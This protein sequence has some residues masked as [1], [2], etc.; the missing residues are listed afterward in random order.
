[1]KFGM[2]NYTSKN[3]KPQDLSRTAKTTLGNGVRETILSPNYVAFPDEAMTRFAQER[4]LLQHKDIVRIPKPVVVCQGVVRQATTLPGSTI[5]AMS[6]NVPTEEW[7][8]KELVELAKLQRKERELSAEPTTLVGAI[9]ELNKKNDGR[10]T[11]AQQRLKIKGAA[12]LDESDS[13]VEFIVEVKGDPKKER[14]EKPVVRTTPP[15]VDSVVVDVLEEDG[16]SDDPDRDRII[17]QRLKVKLETERL[18]KYEAE[19]V[20]KMESRRKKR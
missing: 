12:A 15:V 20:L 11:A 16:D 8:K 19:Y 17:L 18:A 2:F 14:G 9:Q 5:Q 1:M 10:Q 13:S 7:M 3:V 4:G 6:T